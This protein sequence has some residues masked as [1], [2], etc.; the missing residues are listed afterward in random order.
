MVVGNERLKAYYCGTDPVEAR[1]ESPA[2]GIADFWDRIRRSYHLAWSFYL[3]GTLNGPDE[4]FSGGWAEE[5]P[6]IGDLQSVWTRVRAALS[7]GGFNPPPGEYAETFD[8]GQGPADYGQEPYPGDSAAEDGG[9][10]GFELLVVL[11]GAAALLA[12][13]RKG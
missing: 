5:G 3:R 4:T 1:N 8:D 12:S 13:E 6:S 9:G 10:G 7:A 2:E 11:V